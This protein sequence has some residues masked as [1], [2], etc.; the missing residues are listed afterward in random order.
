MTGVA[1][2]DFHQPLVILAS[3][4]FENGNT[5]ITQLIKDLRDAEA[6]LKEAVDILVLEPVSSPEA[7]ICRAAM[8]DLKQLR[9]YIREMEELK[10][11]GVVG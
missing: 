10:K 3:K 6:V 4:K 11:S 2:Y 1:L 7:T 8:N 9:D 5:N